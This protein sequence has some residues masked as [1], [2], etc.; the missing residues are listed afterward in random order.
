VVQVLDVVVAV[1]WAGNNLVCVCVCDDMDM[2]HNG[3]VVNV[4]V[5]CVVV[6]DRVRDVLD[7]L[8]VD[9]D[10][11]RLGGI[12]GCVGWGVR[13]LHDNWLRTRHVAFLACTGVATFLATAVRLR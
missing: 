4:F 11:L 10:D 6:R 12:R 2:V 5:D 13:L 9:M 3:A 7:M 1:N 8:A